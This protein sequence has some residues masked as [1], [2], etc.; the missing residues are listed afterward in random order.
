MA[1]AIT[2]FFSIK[3]Q[4]LG[5]GMKIVEQK[6]GNTAIAAEFIH[7]AIG[8]E[9]FEIEA[10]RVYS[11]D[12]MTLINEAK[13]ELQAG[14]RVEVKKYPESLDD[15]DTIFLGYP[16]WWNTMPMVMFTFL[17]HYD[18]T[19]K[20]IIPFCTNEGSGFGESVRD[21]KKI[22]KG[23]DVKD[24]ITITGSQVKN[25]ENRISAWAKGQL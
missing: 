12:H 20:R 7:N 9:L 19:G 5:A 6:K 11:K 22:A 10:A 2:I 15:Y 14:T 3:G 24:G 13:Q 18:W 4:T 1:K 17:E 23:S 8:G 21:I 16:N 25:M